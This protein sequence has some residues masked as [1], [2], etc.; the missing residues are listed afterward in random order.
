[1]RRTTTIWL[2]AGALAALALGS[3][4]T[5]EE[6]ESAVVYRLGAPQRVI[7]DAGLH[8]KWP[9][10][11]DTVAHVDR[12]VHLLDPT[13]GEYLTG[14]QRNIIVDAFVAWRVADPRAFLVRLRTR[15]AAE[16]NLESILAAAI[17]QVMNAGPIADLLT[18]ESRARSLDTV[19]EELATELRRRVAEDDSGLAVELAGIKRIN[20]PDTNKRSVEER[21]R[22]DRE[23]EVEAILSAARTE[24][25]E[26]RTKAET[27]IARI[28]TDAKVEASR[29]MGEA[30]A[31]AANLLG[32]QWDRHPVLV[33]LLR[34]GELFDA[35][36]GDNE[37]ILSSEHELLRVFD[38]AGFTGTRSS[39]E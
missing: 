8:F 2:F 19:A 23:T 31:R 6:G 30:T 11:L 9:A 24:A 18:I 32:E 14:D 37:F 3:G 38:P 36:Q 33:E 16:A 7:D 22:S 21:M 39:K 25:A 15:E 13:P 12:R 10:P 28:V 4:F 26:I 5:V 35:T 17:T 29:I 34:V 1:M 20:F 27:E